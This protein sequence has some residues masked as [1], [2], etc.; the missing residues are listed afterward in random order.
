MCEFPTY[1]RD[2]NSRFDKELVLRQRLGELSEQGAAANRMRVRD[3]LLESNRVSDT[4]FAAKLAEITAQPDVA[5]IIKARDAKQ[6]SA[7]ALRLSFDALDFIAGPDPVRKARAQCLISSGFLIDLA[8]R[9]ALSERV[10]ALM[11]T[12]LLEFAQEKGAV[13]PTPL[14][15]SLQPT[16]WACATPEGRAAAEEEAALHMD[17]LRTQQKNS[18]AELDALVKA[19]GW[20]PQKKSQVFKA[21]LEDAGFAAVEAEK[22]PVSA[23]LVALMQAG[24][25]DMG[26]D[27]SQGPCTWPARMAPK[28]QKI[29]ELNARQYQLMTQ[30]VRQAE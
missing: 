24:G 14:A 19:K 28:L 16:T 8:K 15:P 23:E 21:L 26:I 30:F 6:L 3:A 25:N 13:P 29:G 7:K 5:A 4:E 18:E 2:F 10:A 1:A 22:K 20:N 12:R 9:R 11:Q 27:T 17:D